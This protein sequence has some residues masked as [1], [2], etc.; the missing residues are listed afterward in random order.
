MRGKGVGRVDV[1]GTDRR[2]G[3]KPAV[4]VDTGRGRERIAAVDV[5]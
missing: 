1:R 4:S 3:L 5:L 2:R